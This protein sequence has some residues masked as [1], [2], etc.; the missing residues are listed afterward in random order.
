MIPAVSRGRW[1]ALYVGWIAICAILFLALSGRE[2]PSRRGDRILSND[3]GRRALTLLYQTDRIRYR[4][5][6]VVHVAYAGAGEGGREG[7]WVVLCDGVPHTALREAVVVELD[8]KDGRLLR[9]R[10]PE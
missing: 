10:K 1:I 5:F 4:D 9:T 6:E 3:A 7:R 2:D 8:A